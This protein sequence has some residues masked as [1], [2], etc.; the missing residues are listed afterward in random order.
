[1]TDD[2]HEH[3][4]LTLVTDRACEPGFEHIMTRD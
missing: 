2:P 3:P 4:R 1:M